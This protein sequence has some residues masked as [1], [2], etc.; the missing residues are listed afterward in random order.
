MAVLKNAIDALDPSHDKKKELTLALNLLA[1]L[2]EQKVNG[3][4]AAVKEELR[5]A[6]NAE[7][8]TIPVTEIIARHTEYRAY[9]KKDAGKMAT[10][11]A[12]AVKKFVSGGA[13][14]IID[15]IASLV[16]TGLEA[17]IGGGS[18]DQEE[19]GSYY[20]VVQT[21]GIARYDIRAWSRKIEA[22]GITS[23]IETALAL[24]A[25]KSSVDVMKISFNTF[26]LAYGAQLEAMKFPPEKQKEY[27]QYAKE[28]FDMLRNE[29]KQNLTANALGIDRS[30]DNLPAQSVGFRSPGEFFGSLW[31]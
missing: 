19:M 8:K 11:V 20:I 30:Y 10:E 31:T 15:G 5:T 18:G 27:I 24:V 6:G 26:L 3:F 4:E 16:T 9:V 7:N 14:D 13:N 22:V 29:G 25:F 28:I 21:Y 2:C 23:Q 17:I 1:E 12:A